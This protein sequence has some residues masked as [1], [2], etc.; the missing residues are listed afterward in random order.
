MSEKIDSE[1]KAQIKAS[2]ASD[3]DSLLDGDCSAFLCV[4]IGRYP[5]G[6]ARILSSVTGGI[7]AEDIMNYGINGIATLM[8]QAARMQKEDT[9]SVNATT[10]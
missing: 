5:G 6:A 3:L 10:H 8:A 1:K 7:P 9:A 2:I 4:M